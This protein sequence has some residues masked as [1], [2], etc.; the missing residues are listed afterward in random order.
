MKN[1]ALA[2]GLMAALLATTACNKQNGNGKGPE[3]AQTPKAQKAAGK[4][5]CIELI[6]HIRAI[7][8]VHGVHLMA[9][10]Q[11]ESVAEVIDRS[12]VLA[13]RRPWHPGREPRDQADRKTS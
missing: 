2:L 12:G 6:Q 1:H 4:R 11:E 5:L 3:A 13:G 7:E 10:R 9:Y 8:G